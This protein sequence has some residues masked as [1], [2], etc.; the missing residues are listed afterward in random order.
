MVAFIPPVS[1]PSDHLLAARARRRRLCRSALTACCFPML[2]GGVPSVTASLRSP[3]RF[4]VL[5]LLSIAVL[6]AIGAARVYQ[7][8]PQVRADDFAGADVAAACGEYWSS[9]IAV[10]AFDRGRR[11][12]HA[13]LAQQPPGS[14][15]PR[16]AGADRTHVVAVRNRVSGAIDRSLAAAGQRIQRVSAGAATCALINELPRFPERDVIDGCARSACRYILIN[17]RLLHGGDVRS[18]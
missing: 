7:R 8:W 3:A 10:R 17:R 1:R 2:A 4:G 11:E 12:A 5:V 18:R 14:G 15:G 6:A 9:P 16:A 13:W